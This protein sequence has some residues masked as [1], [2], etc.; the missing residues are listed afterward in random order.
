MV[1]NAT[2]SKSY[3]TNSII[4]QNKK[5]FNL[6]NQFNKT[7][8]QLFKMTKG[9]FCDEDIPNSN[10]RK[11]EDK[12]TKLLMKLNDIF[13]ELKKFG[14]IE[15]EYLD[16][17]GLNE[18]FPNIWYMYNEM[19]DFLH[20]C[21]RDYDGTKNLENISPED[22]ELYSLSEGLWDLGVVPCEF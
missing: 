6:L 8:T 1:S 17:N 3:K 20:N 11:K 15:L 7:L 22:N 5:V 12:Y 18:T 9:P 19:A 14:P 13:D 2:Q 21:P 16:E 4:F 10:F